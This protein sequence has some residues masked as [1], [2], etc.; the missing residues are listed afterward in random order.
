[1]DSLTL[2]GLALLGTVAAALVATT[3]AGIRLELAPAIARRHRMR[4]LGRSVQILADEHAAR[5][6]PRARHNAH[7]PA[8][9]R[10]A[11]VTSSG[12]RGVRTRCATHGIRL[13]VTKR[14]GERERTLV[15]LTPYRP[16]VALPAREHVPLVREVDAMRPTYRIAD[17]LDTLAAGIPLQYLRP[18]AVAA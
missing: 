7:C 10:F 14:I 15:A 9:G 2:T 6:A 4:S 3:S 13:R 12:P 16:L 1:M 17:A 8:C 11:R 18:L 5:P